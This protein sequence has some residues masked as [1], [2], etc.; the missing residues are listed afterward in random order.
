M[1]LVGENS[2]NHVLISGL[3]PAFVGAIDLIGIFVHDHNSTIYCILP[4]GPQIQGNKNNTPPNT[5]LAGILC[6]INH[7]FSGIQHWNIFG[8][9][10]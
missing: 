2:T 1:N 8:Y 7:N 5:H 10:N 9:D 4:L 3:V 6:C